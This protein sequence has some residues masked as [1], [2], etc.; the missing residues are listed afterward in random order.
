MDV[1]RE[2]YFVTSIPYDPNFEVQVDGEP[3]EAKKVNMAFLGFE[4]GKGR[5]D[6]KL[7]YHAPGRKAGAWC[8]ALGAV[9]LLFLI[10]G[11][12]ARE[13]APIQRNP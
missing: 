6:V 10:I 13:A 7:V 1:E 9:L 5:H 8:S 2:G 11:K 12:Y 3:V 4:I